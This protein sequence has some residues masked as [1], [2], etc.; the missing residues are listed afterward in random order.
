[1]I[2]ANPEHRQ[3]V[4]RG[5]PPRQRWGMSSRPLPRR[6]RS[7]RGIT[8]PPSEGRERKAWRGAVGGE[9]DGGKTL[10]NCRKSALQKMQ[11]FLED[12]DFL[13]ILDAFVAHCWF[14]GK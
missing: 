14:W 6:Q 5:P 7:W 10:K 9:R 1:M 13:G 8:S 2:R 12:L 11:V 4:T 3:L